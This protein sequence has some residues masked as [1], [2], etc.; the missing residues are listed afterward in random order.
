MAKKQT[1]NPET[2]SNAEP[3]PPA[4]TSE[5]K[6]TSYVPTKMTG[7]QDYAYWWAYARDHAKTVKANAKGFRRGRIWS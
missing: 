6:K 1:T 5:T 4:A 2:E 7:L 3:K